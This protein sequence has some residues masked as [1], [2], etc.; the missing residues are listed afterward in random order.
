VNPTRAGAF[1][2]GRS[3]HGAVYRVFWPCKDGF[4]NFI[5][6]G[7]VAGRR[8]NEGM[9]AWMKAKGADL[10]ALATIDWSKFDSTQTTQAQVDAMEAPIAKFLLGITKAEFLQE[11]FEREM[12]GYPVSNV[13]DIAHDPQ[14]AERGFWHDVKDADGKAERFCGGFAIVDGER[15]SVRLPVPKAGEHARTVLSEFGFKAAEIDA[16]VAAGTVK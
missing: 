13:G 10:G 7:G 8:T 4:V 2:T 3:V 6:Y 5:I 16:L 15:L 9:C 12:L 1:M 14:L 11:T